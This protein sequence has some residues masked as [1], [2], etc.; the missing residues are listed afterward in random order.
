MPLTPAQ[1]E[2]LEACEEADR[3]VGQAR[4]AYSDLLQVAR[5]WHNRSVSF[6]VPEDLSDT[7]VVA[8]L[9]ALANAERL[10]V[11]AAAE[12]IPEV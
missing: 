9:R 3:R 7:E 4:S 11:I 12:E 2:K 1:L 6:L 8:K 5:D 10:N